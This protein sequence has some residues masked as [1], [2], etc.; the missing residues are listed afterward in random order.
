MR[1]IR[2]NGVVLFFLLL[3]FLAI[4]GQAVAGYRVEMDDLKTHHEATQSFIAYVVS[5]TFGS[6]LLENWQSEFLQFATFIA[7]TIWLVQRGSAEAKA[8]KDA[9]FDADDAPKSMSQW[10]YAHSL[11]IV[12]TTLFFLTWAGQSL[13]SW[14]E[15]NDDEM[16]HHQDVLTWSQYIG[17]SDFWERTFQNWQSEFLA[18]AAMA[19]FTVFLRE[20]GSPESKRLD[21]SH[22]ANAPTY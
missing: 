13:S 3:M 14:R 7:A 17:S 6:H 2:H 9:G 19:I 15:F 8:P 16:M 11:L 5:P 10:F 22:E 20:R 21:A 12:M 4:I 18:V 1:V